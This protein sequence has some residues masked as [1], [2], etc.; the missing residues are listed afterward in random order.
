MMRCLTKRKESIDY[1]VNMWKHSILEG[2]FMIA[3]FAR[4]KPYLCHKC[5][6]WKEMMIMIWSLLNILSRMYHFI[7]IL[8]ICFSI[9]QVTL[10]HSS[11]S[12]LQ[13]W[14]NQNHQNIKMHY[15]ILVYTTIR[16]FLCDINTE[17][18]DCHLSDN[19]N[20]YDNTASVKK[21][22]QR[23]RL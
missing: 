22:S 15:K 16:F 5:Y 17:C 20:N 8:R 6:I 21:C 9:F 7:G 23:R 3:W 14:L 2:T 18:V 10:I 11:F 19:I 1:G 13:S 12:C 4:S